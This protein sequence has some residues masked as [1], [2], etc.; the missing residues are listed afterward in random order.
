MFVNK[1]LNLIKTSCLIILIFLFFSCEK[2]DA[3]DNCES[4][5]PESISIYSQ[6]QLNEF[7]KCNYTSIEGRLRLENVNDL[8]GLKSLVSAEEVRIVYSELENL[9]GLNN[10][11][12]I[13]GGIDKFNKVVEGALMIN[14]TSITSLKG[15]SSLEKINAFVVY[16]NHN[17]YDYCD[18]NSEVF[19][20]ENYQVHDNKFNP[21]KEQLIE[22]TKCKE[23]RFINEKV[24]N[25]D[26]IIGP[27][28]I[29]ANFETVQEFANEGYSVINGS[30]RIIHT[31]SLDPLSKLKLIL[32]NFEIG[33]SYEEDH[34]TFYRYNDLKN[35]KGLDSLTTIE[36]SF[37]IVATLSLKNLSGLEN[38]K[39]IGGSVNIVNN[40]SLENLDGLEAL[41]KVNSLR[42]ERNKKLESFCAIKNLE[43][44]F[45]QVERNKYNPSKEQ[46]KSDAECSN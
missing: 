18:V 15:L 27:P 41:K 32:G 11:K 1:S 35:L 10:L 43:F 9:E 31:S 44:T 4:V 6:K 34:T 25:G 22:E 30:L 46:I 14:G 12:Y 13:T 20:F 39:T 8:S 24:F 21:K 5:Y 33:F 40:P 37:N 45:F 36:G 2:E 28:Y 3:L 29:N 38:L 23:T 16:N 7:T 42:I 26:V 17:L 19:D